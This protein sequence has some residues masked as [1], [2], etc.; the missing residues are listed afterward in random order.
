MRTPDPGMLKVMV[1][2]S[3][4]ALASRIAC[5]REPGPL[6]LVLVTTLSPSRIVRNHPK[7]MLPESVPAS[8]TTYRCQVPLAFVPA[9]TDRSAP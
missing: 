8:S 2:V 6:L 5:R 1:L 7:A 4:A 9:K 3:E